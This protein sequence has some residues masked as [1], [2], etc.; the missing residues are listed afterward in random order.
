V[1]EVPAWGRTYRKTT[2]SD[3]FRGEKENKR[4]QMISRAAE[5]FQQR[6]NF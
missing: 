3:G 2:S 4:N 5:D 1:D 6:E